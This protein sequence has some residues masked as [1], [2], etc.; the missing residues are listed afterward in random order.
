MFLHFTFNDEPLSINARSVVKVGSR[1]GKTMLVTTNGIFD[2]DQS[3]PYTIVR[4]EEAL[5]CKNI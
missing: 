2:I 3:Y 5:E 1:A 4:L